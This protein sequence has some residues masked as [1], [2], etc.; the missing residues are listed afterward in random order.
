MKLI[1]LHLAAF[2]R[3]T[4]ARLDF[5][6]DGAGLHVIHGA[7]EAGKSTA[8]RALTDLLFGVPSRT[9]DDFHHEARKLRI[10]GE[11]LAANGACLAFLRRKGNSRTILGADGTDLDDAALTPFV[12]A[13]TRETFETIFR[14]DHPAL[15]AGGKE[16]LEGK[17]NLAQSLFQAAAGITGLR[18]TLDEMEAEAGELFRSNATRPRV[19]RALADYTTARRASRDAALK[20]GEWSATVAS[21][22]QLAGELNELGG[23][24]KSEDRRLRVMER[25]F[26]ALPHAHRRAALLREQEA[27]GEVMLLPPDA[28]VRREEA[29]KEQRRLQPLKEEAEKHIEQLQG[30]LGAL[31]AAPQ[32]LSEAASISDLAQ[33]LREYR[34]AFTELPDPARP[35]RDLE[36]GTP[37]LDRADEG[38]ALHIAQL[39]LWS[40]SI[41]ELER[42]S[43]P[44]PETVG[45]FEKE[46]AKLSTD[47]ARLVRE[48]Q[49]GNARLEQARAQSRALEIGGV[50]PT[51]KE[52]LEARA[53]RDREW[54][55]LLDAWHEVESSTVPAARRETRSMEG[56]YEKAVRDAD[57]VSD[58]LRREADRV[59]AH[60]TFIAE[61]ERGVAHLCGLETEM[62]ALAAE[63]AEKNREWISAWAAA[64]ITP[65]T[66]TEMQPWLRRHEELLRLAAQ[67]RASAQTIAE[68]AARF[69]RCVESF[70]REAALLIQSVAPELAELP[71]DRAVESLQSRLTQAQQDAARRQQIEQSL[72]RER[73][74]LSK[75][76]REL[77]RIRLE[78]EALLSQSRCA[79]RDALLEAEARSEKAR[80]LAS[81]IEVENRAL[82]GHAG[83]QPLDDFASEV[84]ALDRE[85]LQ[86]EIAKLSQL[87]RDA[88]PALA[89]KQRQFAE[90]EAQVKAMDGGHTAAVASEEA[91]AFLAEARD[92][93][94]RYVR[95]HLAGAI[96]RRQIERYRRE[97]QD[98]VL[99][100]A[101][102]LFSALTRGSFSGIVT[103]FREKDEPVLLG[104]RPSEEEVEVSGMSEGTRDQLY[105]ALRV[106]T[107]ERQLRFGEPLPFVVDDV[108]VSFD[109]QRARAALGVL[110]EL[111][112]KTQVLFFTHH[113]HLV[114]LARQAVPASLF[115]EHCLGSAD[116]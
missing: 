18:R 68:E 116:S 56:A 34:A 63:T 60:A 51:E 72:E 102:A 39:G 65:S 107:L 95:L 103:D 62:A 42:L 81:E 91:Q 101:S 33:R 40:G 17:G 48:R 7:N 1:S 59:A 78:L 85:K 35:A 15:I 20:P 100:R 76:N 27:L 57:L 74:A 84:A 22:D 26:G 43:V 16:L 99:H 114:E 67:R 46:F 41:A 71:P 77:T 104:I 37:Q 31:N 93:A 28:K 47:R 3:F 23:K 82:L 90:S 54:Q 29:E 80:R 4:D 66:P 55:L 79:T 21:R 36:R 87:L 10:G 105:L 11:L 24:L 50:V 89:E 12:G 111:C 86:E 45:R 14:L 52:L 53:H 49:E 38:I 94:E 8:M 75:T 113:S 69:R 112:A 44:A 106:A 98:P 108:L 32:L 61:A 2:G 83:S 88:E 5:G 109:D 58:R 92:A 25:Q 115:R 9:S 19:N 64:R 96:L 110:S 6:S 70:A 30:Q 13:A 73:K 97:N